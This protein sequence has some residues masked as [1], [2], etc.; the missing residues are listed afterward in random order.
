MKTEFLKE[1]GISDE[2][3]K[4]IM[5]ENGK[6]VQAEKNKTAAAEEK[7]NKATETIGTLEHD[8]QDMQKKDPD[9]LQK[10][11]TE[12]Q[13]VIDDR[14]AEDEKA[15]LEKNLSERFEKAVGDGKFVNDITKNGIF[16]EFKDALSDVNNKG[17]SDSDIYAA[18]TKDRAGIFASQNPEVDVPGTGGSMEEIDENEIRSVMG[19]PPIKA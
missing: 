12:L 15:I 16:S 8:L 6:D 3:I 11:I 10:K 17:K 14:K 7:L 9:G 4:A 18:L 13:K 5:A 2:Q 19:L 1:L